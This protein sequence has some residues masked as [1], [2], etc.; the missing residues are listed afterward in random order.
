MSIVWSG[1]YGRLNGRLLWCG[2]SRRTIPPSKGNLMAIIEID[3]AL[4]AQMDSAIAAALDAF[5]RIKT[6]YRETIRTDEEAV[7]REVNVLQL[8]ETGITALRRAQ[9]PWIEEV[10]QASLPLNQTE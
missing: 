8:L 7:I 10:R 1:Q 2:A 3:P 6:L 9:L 4:V 5:Y